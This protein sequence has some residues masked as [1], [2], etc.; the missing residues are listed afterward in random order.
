MTALPAKDRQAA[1]REIVNTLRDEL[2]QTDRGV[3]LL[4]MELE[5]RVEERTAELAEAHE[6]LAKTN[7]DLMQLTLELDNRVE[8]RTAEL[9]REV[10]ERTQAEE[11]LRESEM[12]FRIV[13]QTTSDF[14]YERDLGTGV[15]QFFGHI[16]ERLGYA[17][18]EFPRDLA[19]WLDHVHPGDRARVMGSIQ[20]CAQR[21]EAYN[22]EYRLR[23]A[24]GAYVDW[25]DRGVMLQDGAGRP[26]KNIGA[27]TD[28]SARKRAEEEIRRLNESL[29]QRVLER[30]AQLEA[31]NK[32]L[33]AF[34]YSVSHDLRSPLRA[35][36][37]YAKI[38]EEDYQD[39]LD[40]EGCR[41]LAVVR[42]EA[43]RMG[44]LIDDLLAFSRLGRQ[45][46]RKTATDMTALA[47]GVF[48]TLLQQ[49]TGRSV[50]FQL[51]GLAPAEADEALM[52]QVWANLIGNAIKYSRGRD[53]AR[54]EVESRI[55]GEEAI[56]LVKDNGA[57]FDMKYADKLFGVFQRLHRQDEFEGTGV[58]LALVQRIVHRHG[59]RVWAEGQVDQGATFYFALPHQEL[60]GNNSPPLEFVHFPERISAP[61]GA[62]T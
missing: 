34:S 20:M 46:M 57:G 9:C 17:S 43:R 28:I 10:A 47:R 44:Q 42:S 52:R 40:A 33:D 16:D 54:I 1:A 19:G 3:L 53:P 11:R 50:D 49:S 38:L 15:A 61:K 45:A 55:E 51:A 8:E 58:G 21:G 18:D 7:T 48:E 26:V 30:T 29:E 39:R 36:D 41:V 62:V 5:D 22:V 32:E 56:Y 12:R 2:F 23:K 13:A 6:E 35:V 4:T 37:G 60:A 14:I 27:A 25:W 59:G 24:D 31:A